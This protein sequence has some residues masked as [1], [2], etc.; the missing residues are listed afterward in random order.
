MLVA[1]TD[2]EAE[3]VVSRLQPAETASTPSTRCAGAD[4]GGGQGQM[5]D[6]GG[7]Y[8]APVRD[9]VSDEEVA[10]WSHDK[11]MIVRRAIMRRALTSP[12]T[13]EELR[14][15]VV[16]EIVLS[17]GLGQVI[18]DLLGWPALLEGIDDE[19]AARSELVQRMG[20]DML[21]AV[22]VLSL[23]DGGDWHLDHDRIKSRLAL[24]RMYGVDVLKPEEQTDDAGVA[25]ETSAEA[26]R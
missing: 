19:D 21:G 11:W 8:R 22:L 7:L 16:R 13:V 15:L 25:G 12:R 4:G 18:E 5:F 26:S 1:L 24:A 14:G 3:A 23:I 2:D 17:G 6:G 10:V 9:A 20:P